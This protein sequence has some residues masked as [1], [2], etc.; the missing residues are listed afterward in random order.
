MRDATRSNLYFNTKTHQRLKQYILRKHGMKRKLMSV[1]VD[2]AV[3]EMLDRLDSEE[4]K[5]AH[6]LAK[7][8]GKKVGK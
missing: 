8:V 6:K 4:R 2:M 3:N 5:F 1:Y 7:V